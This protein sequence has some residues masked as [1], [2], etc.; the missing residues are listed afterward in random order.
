MER[1]M[2]KIILAAA[3]GLATTSAS[4]QDLYVGGVL[5]Y[6]LPHSGDAQTA[7]GVLVGAGFQGAGAIGYGV[8]AEY[9]LA[10]SGGTTYDAARLRG[11]ATY[12]LGDI[13]GFA[14]LG[15]TGYFE[16]GETFSGYNFGLGGEVPIGGNGALRVEMMRDMMD[17]SYSTNVTTTRI[18]YTFGF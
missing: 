4:A 5:D 7:A 6:Q 12:D 9:G 18:G 10:L 8:E 17:S 14:T 13:T 15:L 2:N 11:R 16:G 1:A 3:L